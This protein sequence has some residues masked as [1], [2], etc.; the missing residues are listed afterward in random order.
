MPHLDNATLE[1]VLYCVAAA[2]VLFVGYRLGYWMAAWR[3]S[4]P[5]EESVAKAG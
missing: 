4:K 3:A 5:G 1:V 2:V